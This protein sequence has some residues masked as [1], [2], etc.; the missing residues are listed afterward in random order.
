MRS[1][2]AVLLQTQCTIECVAIQYIHSVRKFS[3]RHLVRRHDLSIPKIIELR[4]PTSLKQVF[5]RACVP[6]ETSFIPSAADQSQS[7]RN[8]CVRLYTSGDGDDRI[9]SY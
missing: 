7:H 3:A 1:F 9:A 4:G 2:D 8:A 5:N 6:N